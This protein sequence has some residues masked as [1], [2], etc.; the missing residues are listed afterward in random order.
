MEIVNVRDFEGLYAVTDE[1]VIYSL[2][3]G[4]EVIP[5]V[6]KKGYKY[7]TLHKNGKRRTRPVHC[8]V[9]Y[10]FHKNRG[11]NRN[12][13]LVIDHIDGNKLNNHLSNLRK[14]TTRENTAR[15]KETP[16]GRGVHY[17]AGLNKYGASIQ[18]DNIR[19]HLGVFDSA[20]EAS[21]VYKTALDNYKTNGVLP[22]KKDRS[23]KYC[24]RC[25]QTLPISQ[26][27]YIKH[28]GLSY[29]CK[30]CSCEYARIQRRNAA[31]KNKEHN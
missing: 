6:N 31:I 14:I 20:E 29:Y 1:G 21:K 2:R 30:P 13:N 5:T 12:D 4:I 16:N 3:K 17:F 24:A 7:V 25:K 15:A 11:L 22:Y 28:H 10:S 8:I 26:F 18:I 9:Y 23:V 27:Y 19:Y